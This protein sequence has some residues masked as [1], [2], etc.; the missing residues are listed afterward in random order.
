M[1]RARKAGSPRATRSTAQ[2]K[3]E[4]VEKDINYQYIRDRFNWPKELLTRQGAAHR[5][6]A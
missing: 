3:L 6:A 5:L 4:R 1:R 2:L